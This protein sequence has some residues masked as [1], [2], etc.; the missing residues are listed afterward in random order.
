MQVETFHMMEDMSQ[1][2]EN[3]GNSENNKTENQ[4]QSQP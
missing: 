2:D 3:F 1:Q 4:F